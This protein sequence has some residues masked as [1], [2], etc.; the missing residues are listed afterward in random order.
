MAIGDI[1][2]AGI[3]RIAGGGEGLARIGN[4]RLFVGLSAPGDVVRV[5]IS[6]EHK[7]WARAEILEIEEASPLRVEPVCPVYGRCGG[8]SLQH[9]GYEAQL[10]A[11]EGI[12]REC[13]SRIAGLDA[14]DGL[15]SSVRPSVPFGYRNRVQFHCLP[16][17]R[18]CLGFK[19]IR[20]SGV[21][22][23]SGCPVAE[24]GIEKALKEG[25]IKPPPEKDRFTVYSL[26][27]LFLSEGGKSRG[28]ISIL[29]KNYTMDAGLFFQSN[30]AML[31]ALLVDLKNAAAASNHDLPL[32]DLYCGIGTFAAFLG[33]GFP[34][35]ELVEKNKA[36]LALARENVNNENCRFYAVSGDE[37]AK[38]HSRKCGFMVVDPPRE[39]MSPLLRKSLAEKGPEI[40]A[41][42]SCDPATLARDAKELTAV[43]YRLGEIRLYDFYPQTA[44]IES[45][46]VFYREKETKTI[47]TMP[48]DG[49]LTQRQNEKI[50]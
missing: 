40:L 42:V 15:I 19:A 13:F 14:L 29:G 6:E 16:Q 44:H 41:Y 17:D 21:V 22:P 9:L 43:S 30:A 46:A 47:Y 27:G 35:L 45:L 8:C 32:A 23:L 1:V 28:S 38:K 7:N 12:V 36:A 4:Q 26:D 2:R 49:K 25:T 37:W 39:G 31:E 33:D 34:S 18:S 50:T 20:D 5:K 48:E 24:K 11:K 3:E 10:S